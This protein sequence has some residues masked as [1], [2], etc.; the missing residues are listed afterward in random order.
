MDN[1]VNDW[2]HWFE[3]LEN[4]THGLDW[5]NNDDLKDKIELIRCN[6]NSY[7]HI[8]DAAY[9]EVRQYDIDYIFKNRILNDN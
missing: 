4:N 8:I 5:D 1:F 3:I 9:D 7:Q 2:Q 6:Y